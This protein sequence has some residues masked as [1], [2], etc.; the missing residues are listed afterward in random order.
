MKILQ[1][2]SRKLSTDEHTIGSEKKIY[3]SITHVASHRQELGKSRGTQ[4]P[5]YTSAEQKKKH[6]VLVLPFIA[7]HPDPYRDRPLDARL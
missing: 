6:G 2:G 5:N 1:H 3:N 4:Q 7:L